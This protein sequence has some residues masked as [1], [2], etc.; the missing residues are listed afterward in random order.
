MKKLVVVQELKSGVDG[1]KVTIEMKK[2]FL[3]VEDQRYT[4][5]IFSPSFLEITLF[6]FDG[7]NV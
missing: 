7:I 2:A 6:S 5:S 4:R 1:Q 3:L